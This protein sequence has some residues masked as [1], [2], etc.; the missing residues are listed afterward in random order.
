LLVRHYGDLQNLQSAMATA[1]VPEN[2][3]Y[4]DLLAIDGIGDGVAA[5]LVAFFHEPQNQ[6]ILDALAKELT[7]EPVEAPANVASAISGRTIVFTGGLEAMS[8]GEAKARA[9]ALGAKVVGSVSKKTDVVVAG[10]DAGSK[11]KKAVEL[12]L[13]IWTEAEW[14]A[15]AAGEQS[16]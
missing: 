1:T 4:Q 3:A 10:T 2:E 16:S 14:L 11:A 6:E 12:G 9:E 8:R 7:I 13:E 15:V 5:D